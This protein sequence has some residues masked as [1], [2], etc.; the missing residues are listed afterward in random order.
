M[1]K[2][3]SADPLSHMFCC[4]WRAIEGQH[5]SLHNSLFLFFI[6]RSYCLHYSILCQCSMLLAFA[7]GISELV[8]AF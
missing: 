1:Y 2:A 5:V 4:D 7:C 3:E 8:N 6:L